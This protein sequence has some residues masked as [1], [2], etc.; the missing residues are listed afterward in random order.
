MSDS[1]FTFSVVVIVSAMLQEVYVVSPNN[2]VLMASL[3]YP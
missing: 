3:V 2:R 1:S